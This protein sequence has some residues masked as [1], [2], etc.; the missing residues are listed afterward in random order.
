[1]V[2]ETKEMSEITEKVLQKGGLLSKL[3]FDMQSEKPEDLQPLMTDLINNRLLKAPG[4]VYGFG[5]IDEPIKLEEIYST[6]AIVTVLVTDL[7]ALID[8]VFNLSPIGIEILKPQGEFVIKSRDL[9][10]LM[11]RLSEISADYNRY[12]LTRVMSGDDLEK[13]KESLKSREAQGK[14]L[15]EKKSSG[16]APKEEPLKD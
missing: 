3:Y 9:N 2:M 6:S 15:L 1:M 14:R 7:G 11:V 8:V 13:V 5:S 12:I 10:T 4:V 16:E